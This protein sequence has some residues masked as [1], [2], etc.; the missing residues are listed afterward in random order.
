[1][2]LEAERI[3]PHCPKVIRVVSIDGLAKEALLA[4]RQR[5][6]ILL[7]AAAEPLFASPHFTTA[8]TPRTYTSVELPVRDLGFPNGAITVTIYTQ[9]AT[10]GLRLCPLGLGSHFRLHYL[11][12]PE[13]DWGSPPA[14]AKHPVARSPS[15]QCRSPLTI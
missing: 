5:N 13:G 14:N 1:M 2:A 9:A 7:N 11:D 10:L 12:Q 4:Q 6:G 3:E 8:A 15:P